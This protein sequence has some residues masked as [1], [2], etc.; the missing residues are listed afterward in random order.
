[1]PPRCGG[2]CSPR[3]ST[4]SASRSTRS[5]TSSA[6]PRTSCSTPTPSPPSTPATRTRRTVARA[7]AAYE[8]EMRGA[9]AL[10]F[11]DLLVRTVQ[12]L[13]ECDPV[14]EDYQTRFRHLFVDEYQDTNLAQYVL[15]K[16]LS[17]KH[18]NL[19]VVGD[20]DQS[21]FGW[22]GADVRNILSF[23]RDYPDAKV[24]TLEQNYRSTQV[25]LD[26]A[27]AVIRH[28]PRPRRQ[29][30]VDRPQRRRAGAADLRVRRAGG[31]ARG[32]RRDRDADRARGLLAERLRG[33]LPHQRAVPRLR[34]RAPA[35]RHPVPARRRAALL[36]AARGEGRPRLPAAG[37][38]PA[39]LGLLRPR[40]Q[41]AAAQDRR[42]HR[43]RARAACAAQAHLALRGGARARRQR[44]DHPGGARR[45]RR[46][47]PAHRAACATSP[48]ACRCRSS[49][50][51]CSTTPATS[52]RC[53]TAR[54]RTRSAGPTSPSS[55]AWPPSTPTCRRRRD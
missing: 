22:R 38:Q 45:A 11:D 43:R 16:L 10:D 53:A 15:V 17:E 34:G 37:R 23:R 31:G 28:N 25:I 14:R 40:G 49:S 30:A 24:V 35:A 50:T 26:A 6:P 52:A 7:F 33:A 47:R 2:R 42:P 27:H 4:T 13:R 18:R 48:S 51:A 1:M 5:A 9:D 55:S 21:I 19:T 41:R 36:R 54:R 39:R 32:L 20:D 29:E 3:A 46:L 12:L 44:R 8:A